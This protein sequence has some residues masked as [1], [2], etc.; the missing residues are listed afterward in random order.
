[1]KKTLILL[2]SLVLLCQCKQEKT[3]CIEGCISDADSCM[4]YLEHLS[5]GKGT[6][7][8]DSVRLGGDGMFCFREEAPSSPEFYRLRI[9]GQ[10]INLAIDSTETV[11]IEASLDSL[12]FGYSVEGSNSCDSIRLLCIKLADVERKARRISTDRN[13]TLQERDS[14]IG[15]LIGQYKSEVKQ[16]FILNHYDATYSYYACFQTFGSGF[17]FNPY[18]DKS[19]LIW[20]R[21]VA[22]AWNEKYPNC[23]R[24]ENLCAIVQECRR[25]Q[26]K[27]REIVLNI[28]GD[29]VRELGI[30]DM[31]FPDINGRE[32]KLSDL[33][34]QV[35]LLD[36]MAF[37]M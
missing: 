34:G 30:I 32:R 23:T 27:P 14:M 31:T 17:I 29:K 22:N 11:R 15:S 10:G 21:A 36:F 2:L 3:F 16:D 9:G 6:V 20:M 12:S 8:I 5:L 26:A 13:Y 7:A 19:D 35:V 33:R 28:D 25:N 24:S 18:Q 1:M 4:L 37:S